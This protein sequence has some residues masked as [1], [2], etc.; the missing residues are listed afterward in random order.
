MEVTNLC[1]PLNQLELP[2]PWQSLWT[3]LINIFTGRG[4]DRRDIWRQGTKHSLG[5]L[6]KHVTRL[7]ATGNQWRKE[8]EMQ[9]EQ[10]ICNKII[11]W[12]KFQF[13]C[14]MISIASMYLFRLLDA[15][16]LYVWY[17]SFPNLVYTMS[18]C[19]IMSIHYQRSLI[20]VVGM[21]LQSHFMAS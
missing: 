20:H 17:S 18:I 13:S 7:Q 5:F 3:H 10:K 4:S 15:N 6:L 11:V 21:E 1:R 12:R 16:S 8:W 14:L 19:H 2:F 9:T